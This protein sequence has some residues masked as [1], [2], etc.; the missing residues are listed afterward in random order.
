MLAAL[1][2][3]WGV[4]LLKKSGGC[5]H[6]SRGWMLLSMPCP[7]CFA[8]I[9]FSAA[10]LRRLLPD[11]PWAFVCLGAGFILVSLISGAGLAFFNRGDPEQGLGA[12][13]VLA[14]LYF[15]ITIA[16]APQFADIERI[17]RISK[18]SGAA[19]PD[20][21]LLLLLMGLAPAFAAGFIQAIRK[22]SWK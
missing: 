17:Y 8:V 10:F 5:E 7:V 9:L 16:V 2:L 4:V 11:T 3:V 13:M 19:M 22:T 15:L 14:A 12:V 20:K 18:S 21:R 6:N 1:L